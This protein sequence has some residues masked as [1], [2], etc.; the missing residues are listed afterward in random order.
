VPEHC[1][2]EVPNT[3]IPGRWVNAID[4]RVGDILFTRDG[5]R[6][7]VTNVSVRHVK[8]KVYNLQVEGLHNYTVGHT[9]ILVHNSSGN[10]SPRV[11]VRQSPTDANRLFFDFDAAAPGGR[12]GASVRVD[13]GQGLASIDGV[14]K[15]VSLPARSTGGL[16]AEG[17]QQS[18][19]PKPAIL[20][21]F[22]VEKSTASA[23]AAGG[24]GQGTLI[25]NML[26]D[27]A[28]G[29]GGTVTRFEPIKDGNIWHLRVHI[30]YP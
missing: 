22:N 10:V 30:S 20:E 26:E 4:L 15:N 14:H 9:G 2:A 11:T 23:L 24:N 5:R 18:G 8:M 27:S 21:G 7:P 13:P 25:G 29:L 12:G 16:L 1:P 3:A 6:V 17:L 28:R 19:M